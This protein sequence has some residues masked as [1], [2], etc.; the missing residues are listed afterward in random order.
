MEFW[1]GGGDPSAPPFPLYA[2]LRAV[3]MYILKP[4]WRGGSSLCEMAVRRK[5]KPCS[6]TCP[7][8]IYCNV[9]N[10]RV[11]I[12]LSNLFGLFFDLLAGLCWR[13]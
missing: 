5:G 12:A 10:P 6:V 7:V 1:G 3:Y 11:C 8:I 2:I 13:C 4:F 9:L